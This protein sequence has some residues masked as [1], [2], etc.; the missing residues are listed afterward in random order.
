MADR[1][2]VARYRLGRLLGAGGMGTVWRAYDELLGRDV[3]IKRIELADDTPADERAMLCARAAREARAAAMLDHPGIVTVHDVVEPDG[4]PWIIMEL[5]E[6]RSLDDAVAAEG[7]F[8]PRRVAAIGALLLDALAAAHTK[9]LLHR[10]VK[11]ANV[12]LADDGRVVLTD[13]GIA[14]LDGDPALTRAGALLGSPGFI[15][16]ERLRDDPSGPASDLWSVGATLYAAVEGRAPYDAATP[17]AALGAV[18]TGDAPPPVR[19]GPLAPVL[20]R[21]LDRDPAARIT[22]ADAAAALRR[23]ADGHAPDLAAP[24]PPQPAPAPGTGSAGPVTPGAGRTVVRTIRRPAG[25]RRAVLVA[26]IVA[27]VLVVAAGVL[28]AR[29]YGGTGSAV[30]T[31]PHPASAVYACRLVTAAQARDLLDGATGRGGGRYGGCDWA[32]A[33]VP[34]MLSVTKPDAVTASFAAARDRMAIKRNELLA[35]VQSERNTMDKRTWAWPYAGRKTSVQGI[36]VTGLKALPGVADEAVTYTDRGSPPYD[37]VNVALRE[38]NVVLE[39]QWTG[40][41][42]GPAAAAGRARRAAAAIAVTLARM[43]GRG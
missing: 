21:M 8:P 11:P 18:L 24:P 27:A 25:R 28:V 5:V 10:D 36:S 4:R 33:T 19:A 38:G 41:R 9:G 2:L 12:L 42:T 29:G 16:P 26:G 35:T 39:L 31:G 6:G 17:L 43:E 32:S 30:R 14:A 20:L 1:R 7:P 37:I 40:P 34:G 23:V 15:A 22:T 13:F 3:A